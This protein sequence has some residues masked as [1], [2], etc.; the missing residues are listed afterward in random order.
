M[1]IDGIEFVQVTSAQKGLDS[2]AGWEKF[3]RD[4]GI[5][6]RVLPSPSLKDHYTLW[7]SLTAEE[8]AELSIGKTLIDRG[9]LH[10]NERYK[11]A[12]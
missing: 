12:N 3:Y 11:D 5:A 7:R 9:C 1:I 4:K 2:L 8:E 6:V 10:Y